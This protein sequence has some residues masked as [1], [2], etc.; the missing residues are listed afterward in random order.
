MGIAS[1]LSAARSGLAAASRGLETT[2]NN[3]ANASTEGYARRT[4]QLGAAASVNVQGAWVGSGVAVDRIQ[5]AGDAL[6]GVR[7]VTTT[8]HASAASAEHEILSMAEAFMVEGDGTGMVEG[9][10]QLYDA[11]TAATTDPS[12]SSLRRAVLTAAGSFARDVAQTS[13]SLVDLHTQ[14][15]NQATSV[16]DRADSLL[17]QVAE[18]NQG[19]VGG[20]GGDLLDRRDQALRELGELIGVSTHPASDGSVTVTLAGHSLVDGVQAQ[21]LSASVVDGEIEIALTSDGGSLNMASHVGGRAAGLVTGM[22]RV[23]GYLGELDTLVE[24]LAT[25]FNDQHALGY[26][27]DGTAGGDIFTIGTGDHV[28]QGFELNSS[29]VDDPTLL[30]FASS[31]AGA[32]GDAGNLQELINLESTEISDGA[33]GEELFLSFLSGVGTDVSNA[34]A[35]SEQQSSVLADLDALRDSIAGVDLDEEAARLV[36]LQAAYQAAARVLATSSTLMDTLLQA[37][38]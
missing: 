29:L 9:L 25:A 7:I 19:I 35:V 8:G 6:L 20:G 1:T 24:D 11:M 16:I 22:E 30:A 33:T 27:P 32:A 21:S 13:N 15:G 18:Y 3:V 38:M 36:E 37:V 12:S 5:R 34:G 28:S 2:A 4:T 14:V 23:D 10:Q 31:S 26:T 17:Q